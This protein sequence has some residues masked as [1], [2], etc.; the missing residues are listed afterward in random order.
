MQ[1]QQPQQ[2]YQ[3]P[4]QQAGQQIQQ[5]S[6]QQTQPSFEQALPR[7]VSSVIYSLELIETDAE[8][9][10]TQAI[11]QADSFTA[12]YLEDLS[13]LVHVQK[14]LLLRKSP[15]AGI[16]GQCTQQAF[17]Q[18]AQRLQQSQ[19]PG[20]QQVAQEAQQLAQTIPQVSQQVVQTGSQQF[21]G[22]SGTGGQSTMGGQSGMG[23]QQ[24]F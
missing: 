4:Q 9:A 18:I 5:Q 1:Q 11:Q 21:G 2:S 10:E 13:E 7:Q 24:P 17:Q 19:V 12:L 3:Q 6:G 15:Q 22:Q 16:V 20:V 14:E 23:G 8:W